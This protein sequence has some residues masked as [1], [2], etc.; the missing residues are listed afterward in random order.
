MLLVLVLFVNSKLNKRGERTINQHVTFHYEICC[1]DTAFKEIK[2]HLSYFGKHIH[3]YNFN[4]C[5][6]VM[7]CINEQLF[8]CA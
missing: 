2:R 4:L 1:T 3:I 7:L 8:A 6:H 5:F